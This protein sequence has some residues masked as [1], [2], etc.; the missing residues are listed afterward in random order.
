MATPSVLTVPSMYGDGILYSGPSDYGSEIA[1]QPVDLLNDFLKNQN[2]VIVDANTFTSSGG[3]LDGIRSRDG[4]FTLPVGTA[5]EIEIRGTT[6]S[7]GITLGSFSGGGNEYGS[8][9]GVHRFVSLNNRLFIRQRDSAGTTTIT[10]LSIKQVTQGSDFD[11]T[12]DTS[13]TRINEEGYIE[14][15]MYLII[16]LLI[17]KK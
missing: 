2:G 1:S 7:N 10:Y 3:S 5:F 15:V 14:D 9:F 4:S 13:G 11:F 8:G 12:R 6:T 17:V 16:L